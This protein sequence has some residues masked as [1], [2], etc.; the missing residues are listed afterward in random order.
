MFI[1]LPFLTECSS[2]IVFGLSVVM[3]LKLLELTE[4]R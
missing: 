4:F 1:Y 3:Y 2:K